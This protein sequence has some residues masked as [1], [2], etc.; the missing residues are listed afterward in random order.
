MYVATVGH[1]LRQ[2]GAYSRY[3]KGWT[4]VP[5]PY[6]DENGLHNL[7][8]SRMP[9]WQGPIIIPTD[10]FYVDILSKNK[11]EL[12]KYDCAYSKATTNGDYPE[13]TCDH[14]G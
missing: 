4:A 6:R 14:L 10:D 11:A 1:I 8:M 9:E 5:R 7:L 12:S 13:Q 3:V 2:V